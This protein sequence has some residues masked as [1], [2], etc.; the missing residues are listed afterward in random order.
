MTISSIPIEALARRDAMRIA[1]LQ[2]LPRFNR[3]ARARMKPC[4]MCRNSL[5][6]WANKI[7][8][9]TV[10]DRWFQ[11]DTGVWIHITNGK[12]IECKA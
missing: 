3:W 5:V 7:E 1:A 6:E 11:A 4:E 9:R 12:Q 8:P 10:Y 2:W